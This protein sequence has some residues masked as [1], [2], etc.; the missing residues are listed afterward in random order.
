[1]IF[2]KPTTRETTW[3]SPCERDAGSS[4]NVSIGVTF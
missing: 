3:T 2:L 4:A 1:L